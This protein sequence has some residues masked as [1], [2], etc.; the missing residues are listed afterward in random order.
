VDN[1]FLK[2]LSGGDGGNGCD[3]YRPRKNVRQTWT[4]WIAQNGI[5]VLENTA[6]MRERIIYIDFKEKFTG[7][8]CKPQLK[9]QLRAEYPGILAKLVRRCAQVY[10]DG[11]NG[12][13]K[14]ASIVASTAALFRATDYAE[15]FS[16]EMLVKAGDEDFIPNPDMAEAYKA[17]VERTG[18]AGANATGGKSLA[19]ALTALGGKR[20]QRGPRLG[21]KWGWAGVKFR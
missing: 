5:M 6:A 15:R 2:E 16:A 10:K 7:N 19:R 9:E 18:E 17:Y 21:L 8:R 13:Q 14:P 3:V 1:S 4:L 12:L 11:K 20:V